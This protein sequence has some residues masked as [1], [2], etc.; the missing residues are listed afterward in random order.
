VANVHHPDESS[1]QSIRYY[2]LCSDPDAVLVSPLRT[3]RQSRNNLVSDSGAGASAATTT[4]SR[5]SG[6]QDPASPDAIADTLHTILAQLATINKRLELQSETLARHDQL[7]GNQTGMTASTPNPAKLG[8][9]NGQTPQAHVAG[10]M[11][12]TARVFANHQRLSIVIMAVIFG[13]N[14]TIRSIDLSL[15][16]HNM[17]AKQIR[18][19]G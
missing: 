4:D 19:H 13:R 14:S 8:A 1:N 6:A 12:T 5:P 3:D 15:I 17:T 16:F 2:S 10:V 9:T 18:Y 11:E 7:L